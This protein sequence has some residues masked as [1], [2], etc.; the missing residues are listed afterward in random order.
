MTMKALD[1]VE[2]VEEMEREIDELLKGL[3]REERLA[4]WHTQTERLRER[5]RKQREALA[6]KQE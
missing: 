4:F 5:Q 3:S 6:L 1:C 2:M